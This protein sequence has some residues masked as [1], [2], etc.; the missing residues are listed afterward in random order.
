METILNLNEKTI[1]I[2]IKN[3]FN[4]MCINVKLNYLNYYYVLKHSITKQINHTE[5]GYMKQ[6]YEPGIPF[7]FSR[8]NKKNSYKYIYFKFILFPNNIYYIYLFFIYSKYFSFIVN[9]DDDDNNIDFKQYSNINTIYSYKLFNCRDYYKIF[10][11][12]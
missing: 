12:I 11:F 6:F 8:L 1:N 4:S 5:S 3:I 10:S 9:N 2:I 7:C